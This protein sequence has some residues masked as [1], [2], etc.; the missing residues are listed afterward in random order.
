MPKRT[1]ISK[2]KEKKLKEAEKKF[3]EVWR[4]IKPLLKERRVKE[5]STAG[6][7]KTFDYGL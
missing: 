1:L 4:K 5:Y 3:Q 2:E 7:W 6:K